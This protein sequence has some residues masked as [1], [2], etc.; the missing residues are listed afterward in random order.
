MNDLDEKS[1]QGLEDCI[2]EDLDCSECDSDI[3]HLL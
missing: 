3:D 1:Q 2:E